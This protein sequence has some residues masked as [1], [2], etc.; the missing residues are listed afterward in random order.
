MFDEINDKIPSAGTAIMS[1]K[2]LMYKFELVVQE[3]DR[4]IM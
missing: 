2:I 3:Q 1:H 4:F